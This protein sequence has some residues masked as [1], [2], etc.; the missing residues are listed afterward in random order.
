MR[1]ELEEV[2]ARQDAVDASIVGDEH[3]GSVLELGER[4]FQRIVGLHHRD[5]RAHDLRDVGLEEAEVPEDPIE[6]RA[7]LDRADEVRHSAE[8]LAQTG[9]WEIPV[10]L[11]Q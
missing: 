1:E 2:A 7:L 11:R 10:L 5:G 3:R 6:Q 8:P 4:R 9:A